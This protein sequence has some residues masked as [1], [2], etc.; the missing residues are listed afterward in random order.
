MNSFNKIWG[1]YRSYVIVTVA[2]LLLLFT[3]S[4][5]IALLN[6][7]VHWLQSC[8]ETWF[9]IIVTCFMLSLS[10]VII[11]KIYY[12]KQHV[13]HTTLA[14]ALFIILFYSYF[15]FIDDEYEFWGSGGTLKKFRV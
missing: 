5:V 7:C 1:I 4:H 6:N 13:A 2:C 11:G 15:R 3:K 10:A 14:F 12:K 8:S 9:A